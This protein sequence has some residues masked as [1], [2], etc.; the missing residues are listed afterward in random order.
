[1]SASWASQVVGQYLRATGIPLLRGRYFT[2]A[3][4]AD[5][6]LVGIINR[7]LAETYWPRQDP[8][9][10][11]L[12]WGL[13]ESRLPWIT[14]VG[15]VDNVKQTLADAPVK[16]QTYQPA[17]QW[18]P[19]LGPVAS[20]GMVYGNNGAIVLRSAL[21]P[22]EMKAAL[23]ASVRSIDPR[24]PLTQVESMERVVDDGQAPRRF[25]T[26]IISAFAVAAV[27][28]AMLGIYGIIAFSATL[29]TQEMAIRL[30]LGSQRSRVVGLILASG[31]KLGLIGGAIGG[32][33]ALFPTRLLRSFLFQVDPLDPLLSRSQPS[34]SLRWRSWFP[35]SLEC[36]RPQSSPARR[37]A[38]SDLRKCRA[39]CPTFTMA[40]SRLG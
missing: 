8:I 5:S 13:P 20:P 17:S 35:S 11:R 3:D 21:P 22:D 10:K 7:T 6:P 26:V 2:A 30:A 29:R 36:A 1:M 33:A 25:T 16:D 12:H 34:R 27:L 23:L 32:A 19:S 38:R 37:F 9:G 28:L 31:A 40:L 14:V 24:L 4:R 18:V 39:G 15:E